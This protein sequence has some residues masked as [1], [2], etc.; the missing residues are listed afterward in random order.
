M[1]T[2]QL[3]LKTFVITFIIILFPVAFLISNAASGADPDTVAMNNRGVALMGQFNYED[4]RQVFESLLKKHPENLDIKVN[5]AIATFNRQKVG[6]EKAALAMLADVLKKDPSH[7]RARYCTALLELHSGNPE[8]ALNL[9]MEVSKDDPDDA[10]A[11]F[12]IAKTLVQLS[13]YDEAIKFFKRSL[14]LDPYMNSSYYGLIMALRQQGNRQHAM[15]MIQQFQ[16]MKQNPRARLTEFKYTRMGRKSEALALNSEK[17]KKVAKPEGPLFQPSRAITVDA[18][19]TKSNIPWRVSTAKDALPEPHITFCD[20][21]GDH[22]TDIFVAA[23]FKNPGGSGNAIYFKN[24]AKETYSLDIDHPLARVTAVNAALWG[25]IDADGIVDVYLCRSGANQ[26]WKQDKD[27]KWMDVTGESNISGG[28]LDTVDGALLDADHDGDL[29]IFLVNADGPNEL[30]NNNRDGSFRLLAAEYGLQGKNTR[31][32][33]VITT[34]IDGDRDVDFIVIN[35]SPPHEIYV[36]NLLW[37]YQPAKGFESFSAAGITAAL[38]GDV[39]SDGRDELYTLDSKAVLNVWRPGKDRIWKSQILVKNIQGNRLALTDFD[40]D[41]T[42]EL[43]ISGSGPASWQVYSFKNRQLKR[44]FAPS[45]EKDRP[46]AAFA[47]LNT[48]QGPAPLAWRPGSHPYIWSPGS[49]RYRFISFSLTGRKDAQANWRSNASG[50]GARLAVRVDSRWTVL[51]SFRAHSG[52]GQHLQPINAGLGGAQKADYIAIDWS[53]GVYQTELDLEPGK[54]HLIAEIQ[55]QLSS[56]PVIFAWNGETFQFISDFLGVGGFGYAVAPGEYSI[57]RPWENFMLPLGVVKPIDNRVTLKLTEPMEEIAYIDAVRLKVYDLPP[58]LHMTLDER[59]GIQAPAPTGKPRYYRETLAPVKAVNDRNQDVTQSIRRMDLKAAPPG[60]LDLRFIGMLKKDH[61]LTLSFPQALDSIAGTPMLLADGWIEYP[62]SQTNFAAWQAGAV[63]RAATIEALDANGQ[64]VTILDQFGYPAGM[65]RQMSVP[66]PD[67]PRGTRK[68]RISSNMEIY[69]DCLTVAYA[70]P[71]ENVTVKELALEAAELEFI[72]FPRR[73]HLPQ[74][75]PNYDF[76][77]RAPLWDT[78]FLEGFYTRFG[79]MADLVRKTD[80]ALAIFGAG[81]SI[82]LEFT[83]PANP[84][85][86]G[87][88]RV[89]V[90][91]TEGWCK[92]MDFYTD[93]G[94]TVEPLPVNGKRSTYAERLHEIYNTR[95]LGGRD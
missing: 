30:L 69:W 82:H 16:R 40:G 75:L 64:W 21:N 59:M 3:F 14:E 83:A 87:W 62:Y 68:L 79:P 51:D 73:V 4:A 39:D 90:L 38:S 12:F 72:G 50:I 33:A 94:Q 71:G 23:A 55:R 2:H 42:L 92:D 13:R 22:F 48:E 81:E 56:C 36:N 6:D 63:Y 46:F 37:Q 54:T 85:R 89:L 61:V 80:N 58:G 43:F 27:G 70:V 86:P 32:R 65:P 47:L 41:G 28:E 52:P 88:T 35:Q 15:E 19:K 18:L 66:L 9:F 34:D 44:L 8:K 1:N 67:L 24:G 45:Y 53:D 26:L 60:P 31:S 7:N 20:I 10:D 77:Y 74:R 5:L 95:Y 25:D 91:E 57:P 49:G 78:R 11:L 17:L 93:K 76:E 29:D 84:P